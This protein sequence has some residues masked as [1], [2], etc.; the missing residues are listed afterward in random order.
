MPWRPALLAIVALT[1][2]SCGQ[3]K[4]DQRYRD[5]EAQ[6]RQEDRDLASEDPGAAPGASDATASPHP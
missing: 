2:F 4:F 6:I 1:L 5:A 3:D